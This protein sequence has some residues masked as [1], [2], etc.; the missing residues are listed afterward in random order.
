MVKAAVED[1]VTKRLMLRRARNPSLI[2]CFGQ[3][4]R[5]AL[6]VANEHDYASTLAQRQGEQIDRLTIVSIIFLPVTFPTGFFRDVAPQSADC[7]RSGNLRLLEFRCWRSPGGAAT[8]PPELSTAAHG[9]LAINAARLRR[10][11][12]SAILGSMKEKS[13]CN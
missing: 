3:G 10:T 2:A 1:L 12:R 6:F 8:G 5:L 11:S 13:D 4:R 9:P 7:F